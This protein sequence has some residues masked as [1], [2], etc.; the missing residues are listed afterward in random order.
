M[1]V[2]RGNDVKLNNNEKM[3]MLKYGRIFRMEDSQRGFVLI[4]DRRADKW[5]SVRTLF[6]HLNVGFFLFS[7]KIA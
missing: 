2:K 5:S 7:M 3:M 1:I 4:I 6:I